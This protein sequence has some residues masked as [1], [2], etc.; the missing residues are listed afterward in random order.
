MREQ[1]MKCKRCGCDMEVA[2]SGCDLDG[3]GRSFIGKCVNSECNAERELYSP[4]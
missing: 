1:E 4:F 3:D 2:L